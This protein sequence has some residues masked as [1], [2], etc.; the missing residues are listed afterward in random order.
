M[1]NLSRAWKA[2]LGAALVAL[3]L[4]ACSPS[5]SVTSAGAADRPTNTA[6]AVEQEAAEAEAVESELTLSQEQAVGQAQS[7]LDFMGFSRL[8]LIDQLEYE[9]FERSD[10]EFAVD[11]LNVE[12]NEQ[13]VRVAQSY[14][15]T[16]NFSRQGL[17]DQLEYEGFTSE[18]A[19]FGAAGV[20]F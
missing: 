18:Q 4:G 9:G 16:M 7:Y 11:S 6:A 13:A 12:W 8:G 1:Q 15:D 5:E 19:A 3:A 2:L 14:L 20:G 10:A 17:I